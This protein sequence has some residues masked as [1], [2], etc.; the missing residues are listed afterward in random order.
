LLKN[1]ERLF[2]SSRDVNKNKAKAFVLICIKSFLRLSV[3]DAFELLTDGGNDCGVDGLYIGDV[4]DG[5]FAVTVFQGKYKVNDFSGTSCYP[6]N[7]VKAAIATVY[8]IFDPYKEITVHDKIRPLIEEIRSRIKDGLIPNVKVVLCNNGCKWNEISQQDIKNAHFPEDQVDFFYWNQDNIVDV[9]R[10]KRPVDDQLQMTGKVIVE[11]LNYRRVLIG[12]ISVAQIANLFNKYNDQLLERN[13]RRY[14]GLQSNRVNLAISE[15]IKDDSKRDNF[16][17][18]NNGITAIC[19]GFSYNAIQQDNHNVR[20]QGF[21]IINGGQTCRTIQKTL[22]EQP[23][24][25]NKLENTFV[26]MRLYQ[27]DEDMDDFVNDI[28]YATNSQN[29]VDLQDLHSNDVYQQNLEMGLKELG[30]TY[31]RKREENSSESS[32]I[33]SSVVAESVLAVWRQ[34]PHQ[35]KFMRKE[36]FG[37]LYHNIFSNLNAAQALLAVFI[38]RY[39]DNQRKKNDHPRYDFIPY[40]AHYIAMRM[41]CLFLRASHV[42]LEEVTHRNIEELIK[43]FRETQDFLYEQSEKDIDDSMKTLYGNRKLSP[44]L[45]SATFR[46]GDLIDSLLK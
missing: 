8:T 15:T 29:P 17:Y 2:C 43:K 7:G 34:R 32:A 41:G 42:E 6:E 23:D 22:N 25:L 38:F 46:R 9:L 40:S 37:K 11:D 20:V 39:S 3:E 31:K 24:L 36:H 16:Y 45:L 18:F 19:S 21:Q 1:Y 14:L 27:I 4:D 35:A 33:H 44:Q 30:Y 28:T 26:L 10:A 12:K 13:I 5:E